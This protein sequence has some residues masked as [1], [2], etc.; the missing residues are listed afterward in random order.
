MSCAK[1]SSVPDNPFGNRNAGVVGI[2]HGDALD[3]VAHFRGLVQRNEHGGRPRR[4][5]PV[6]QACRLTGNSVSIEISPA[7][8][9]LNRISKRHDLAH[10][11][12]REKLVGV[13]LEEHRAR[14]DI[15]KNGLR[16]GGLERRRRLRAG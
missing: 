7:L 14:I 16:G 1:L 4:R 9:F 11:R 3:K 10:A 5:A 15:D 2:L 8:S 13:L 12:R 6:F